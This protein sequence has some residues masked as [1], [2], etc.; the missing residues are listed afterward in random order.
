MMEQR[1]VECWTATGD[2][3]EVSG[4]NPQPHCWTATGDGIEVSKLN[5]QPHCS[6]AVNALRLI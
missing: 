5:P 1:S 4:L 3:I 6:S 2:E